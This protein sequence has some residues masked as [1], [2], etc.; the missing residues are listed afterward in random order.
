MNLFAKAVEKALTTAFE[1]I[2]ESVVRFA[3]E[4]GYVDEDA[5][6]EEALD[7]LEDACRRGELPVPRPP[8]QYE[9]VIRLVRGL[10]AEDMPRSADEV[11]EKLRSLGRQDLAEQ[12]SRWRCLT[13]LVLRVLSGQPR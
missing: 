4:V 12:A 7:A 3:V 1:Q 8:P 13:G 9:P 11:V 2:I 5:T 6:K 10:I